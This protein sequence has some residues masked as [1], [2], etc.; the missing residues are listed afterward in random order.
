MRGNYPVGT[1][2][3]CLGADYSPEECE[4]LRAIER[5][6]RERRRPFPTCR[7]V[8]EVFKSLG[9]RKVANTPEQPR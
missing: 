9:Y 5:Y 4:F 6:K 7:E 1:A 2:T 3:N 8:L